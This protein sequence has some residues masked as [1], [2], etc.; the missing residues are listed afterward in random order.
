MFVFLLVF[1]AN[2][3]SKHDISVQNSFSNLDPFLTYHQACNKS[4]KTS[5]T[6]EAGTAYPSGAPEFTHVEQELPTLP[7][8]LSSPSVLVGFVLLDL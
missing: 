2:T 4:N 1:F 7:E 3:P 8:I 6:R 5:T